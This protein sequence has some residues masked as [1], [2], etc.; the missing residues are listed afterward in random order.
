ML[1]YLFCGEDVAAK[2]AKITELKNKYLTTPEALQFDYSLLH[3][4]K[5]EPKTLKEI[6]ISVH[7]WTAQR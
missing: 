2:D 7:T 5:L 1:T 4:H 6:L 3:A